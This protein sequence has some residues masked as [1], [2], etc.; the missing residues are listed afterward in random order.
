[1]ARKVLNDICS[2]K[3]WGWHISEPGLN[4]GS[5]PQNKRLSN[6]EIQF[7]ISQYRFPLWPLATSHKL[8]TVQSNKNFHKRKK[9]LRKDR[10]FTLRKPSNSEHSTNI[11]SANHYQTEGGWGRS[12]GEQAEKAKTAGEPRGRKSKHSSRIYPLVRNK[13]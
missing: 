11:K 13:D 3:P 4:S 8:P 7:I 12:K 1:M 9:M 5:V 10:W 6:M 2:R